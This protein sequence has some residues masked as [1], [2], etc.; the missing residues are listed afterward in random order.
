VNFCQLLQKKWIQRLVPPTGNYNTVFEISSSGV[1]RVFIT[2][3]QIRIFAPRKKWRQFKKK[4][5]A[6]LCMGF[7]EL[8]SQR[9]GP[10]PRSPPPL[11]TT[12]ISRTIVSTYSTIFHD[13]HLNKTHETV[14]HK[15]KSC[16]L[17]SA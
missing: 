8:F 14:S 13:E 16:F 1:T 6:P 2:R 12:L 7:F 3:G 17:C 5:F 11:V 9:P 15:I 4:F 10:M